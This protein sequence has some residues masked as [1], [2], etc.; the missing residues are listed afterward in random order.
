MNKPTKKGVQ[1]QEN[2]VVVDSIPKTVIAN[3]SALSPKSNAFGNNRRRVRRDST[4]ENSVFDTSKEACTPKISKVQYRNPEDR[5]AI[6]APESSITR[7][8]YEDILRRVSVVIHQH[9]N[10]CES[11]MAR[12]TP[13]QYETGLFHKSKIALFTEEKYSSPQ[14]VYHFVRAP[15]LRLGSLYGIR[16]VD[17]KLSIPSLSEVHTFLRD[18]FVKAQLSAECSIGMLV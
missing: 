5:E 8:N 14:Y 9:I 13:E 10:K 11:T 12:M 17:M 2:D 3:V 7:P 16:K 4:E 15:I 6:V 1:F 18:L